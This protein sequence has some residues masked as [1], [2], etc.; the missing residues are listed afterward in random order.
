VR[1]RVAPLV[2]VLSTVAFLQ[3]AWQGPVWATTWVVQLAAGSAAEAH[4]AG[5]P[6]APTGVAAACVSPT[7]DKVT[8]TWSA[9]TGASTY[10]VYQST[11]AA[12]GPYSQVASGI[13]TLSWASGGLSTGNYWFEVT[14]LQGS[15]WVSALSAATAESTTKSTGGKTC[16]QP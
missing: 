4:S 11:T 9:V 15:N 6:A 14:A 7:N 10:S 5:A 12:G 1:G 13:A 16:T 3:L 2:L 8:V